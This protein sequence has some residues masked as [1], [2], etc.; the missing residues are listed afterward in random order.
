MRERRVAERLAALQL[1]GEEAV[2]V[3]ARGVDDRSSLGRDRL[4]EHAPLP[5]APDAPGELGDQR[6]RALL[7]AEVR[8]AQR[9]VRVEHDAERDIR[10]V[11]AL[12]DHLRSDQHPALRRLEAAQQRADAALGLLDALGRRDRA[13]GL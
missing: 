13:G 6:E 5:S 8:E 2:A 3:V 1:A 11:V 7:G 10:E 4:H 12:G 9:R